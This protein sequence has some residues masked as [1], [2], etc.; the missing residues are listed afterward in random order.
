VKF[1]SAL[2]NLRAL[3]PL[4]GLQVPFSYFLLVLK[5]SNGLSKDLLMQ[6][7]ARV[8]WEDAQLLVFEQEDFLV[9][10]FDTCIIVRILQFAHV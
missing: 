8:Q 9:N 6:Y 7:A 1:H 10:P 4:I 2:Q 5:S 3:Y